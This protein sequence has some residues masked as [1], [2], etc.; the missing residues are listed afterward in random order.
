MAVPDADIA[1]ASALP[2]PLS[3]ENERDG[4][5]ACASVCRVY[6]QTRL[7]EGALL[8]PV[9]WAVLGAELPTFAI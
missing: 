1:V 9:K 7:M 6:R 3:T 2:R 5:R 4:K 8:N